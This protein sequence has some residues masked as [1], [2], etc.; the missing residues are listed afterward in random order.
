MHT[1]TVAPA[2]STGRGVRVS[3]AQAARRT[4]LAD[5]DLTMSRVCGD[6]EVP[7]GTATNAARGG[8]PA[9]VPGGRVYVPLAAF[10]GD[11]ADLVLGEVTVLERGRL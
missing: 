6:R 3:L 7:T 10:S 8:V 11:R 5:S 1:T 2:A 9:S 4:G